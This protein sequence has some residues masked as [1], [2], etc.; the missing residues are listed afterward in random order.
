MLALV[1]ITA[2]SLSDP[3]VRRTKSSIY[4]ETQVSIKA[5]I[6]IKMRVYSIYRMIKQIINFKK[7]YVILVEK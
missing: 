5:A 4:Y 1:E 7:N 2:T 6:P 3:S